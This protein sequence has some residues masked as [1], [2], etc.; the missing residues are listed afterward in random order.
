MPCFIRIGAGRYEGWRWIDF[1]PSALSSINKDYSAIITKELP[2]KKAREASAQKDLD[3]KETERVRQREEREKLALA[4]KE[5][6]LKKLSASLEKQTLPISNQQEIVT[7]TSRESALRTSGL[8]RSLADDERDRLKEELEIKKKEV[9]KTIEQALALSQSVKKM[10]QENASLRQTTNEL[11]QLLV[12]NELER[13]KEVQERKKD[14]AQREIDNANALYQIISGPIVQKWQKSELKAAE[15][16]I[17]QAQEAL[18]RGNLKTAIETSRQISS[19]LKEIDQTAFEYTKQDTSRKYGVTG[20]VKAL[21][22]IGGWANISVQSIDKANPKGA[23]IITGKHISG[24]TVT[25][26]YNLDGRLKIQFSGIADNEDKAH[27]E[28]DALVEALQK[29]YGIKI[30]KAQLTGVASMDRKPIIRKD[31]DDKRLKS[32]S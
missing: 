1:A 22:Y 24:A 2:D 21:A 3:D 29:E 15:G 25:M 31:T 30:T 26:E 18:S 28:Q 20:L 10:S 27:A 12:S 14:E 9:Q 8:Q 17:I 7:R 11:Q 16:K 5:S 6:A 32:Y 13:S 4:Q 23:V 19:L